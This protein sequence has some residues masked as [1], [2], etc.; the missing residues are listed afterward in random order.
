MLQFPPC[1]AAFLWADTCAGFGKTETGLHLSDS[2]L[3]TRTFA[4]SEG[5][6]LTS[7]EKDMKPVFS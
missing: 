2:I 5:K 4:Q 7:G 6:G 1:G 3:D